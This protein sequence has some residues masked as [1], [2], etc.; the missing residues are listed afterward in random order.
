MNKLTYFLLLAIT[1]S[2]CKNKESKVYDL[3]ILN[4]RI[5]NVENESVSEGQSI[6]ISGGE[7]VEI[8]KGV[9]KEQFTADRLIDANGRFL[10][11][12]LWDNHVHFRGGD[13]LVEENKDLLP[14]FLAYGITTVRDAGGD[15]TPNVLKWED[16]IEKGELDGPRIFSSGPK[17]DGDKPA[18]PG[19]IKV[20]GKAEIVAALDSLESLEVDYVKTYDG[21]LSAENYYSII[22]EAEK[23]GLKVTGHMPMSADFL[24]AISLGLDG[25]EHMYYPLKA[26]S[27]ASDS[28]TKL[29]LGYGMIE[30]LIDAYDPK[31]ADEVFAKMSEENVYVT[32]TLYIGKTLSELLEVDHQQDSLLNYIGSGI[33]QTYQGRIEGAKRAKAS[34][35]KMREKMEEISARMIEPMQNAGVSLLAGSDCGAFNSYVYPGESLHGELNALSKAGLSNA[36]TIRTSIIN[37]PEFLDLGNEYGSI[38][39]G[40]VA[41]ILILDKNPLEDIDNLKKINT[42]IKSGRVYDR[43]SL[44]TMLENLR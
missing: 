31:L 14:L 25:A 9:D 37:G 3:V 10:M 26:C 21:N 6:F 8:R 17:L 28:L 7:I 1:L 2:S 16:Q 19:S 32:P 43:K 35:S 44:D 11:P 20:T 42:V 12:G 34:G 38:A 4:A 24:K 29:S 13:T 22:E 27:P 15:I 40:K 41:D 5:I 18:W 33:Q 36:Q 39:S 23:R 30:P